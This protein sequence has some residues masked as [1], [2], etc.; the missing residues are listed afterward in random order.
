MRYLSSVR[1]SRFSGRGSSRRTFIVNSGQALLIGAGL[2]AGLGRARMVGAASQVTIGVASVPCQAPTYAA[3]AQGYFEDEGLQ[4]TAVVSAEVGEI[5]PALT[6]HKIDAGLSTVW[7]VVPPRLPT[8][9]ALGDVVITAPLQRGCL[10]LSVPPSSPVESLADLSGL[11]VAGSKFLYG[12]A[13]FEAGL[14]PNIDITWSAAPLAAD[15]LATLQAGE[16]AAVQSPDGQGALLEVAGVAR[17]I[18]MNNMSPSEVNYCCA[19][20]MNASSIQSDRP[21]AAAITRALMRGSAWAEAN[22]TE[23]AELMRSSMTLPAQRE[24][25][26]DDMEA[27][28][29]MQAFVPMADAARPI[30]ISEF[31]DYMAY[32]LPVSP[33]MDTATL[34]D[35]IFVPL[36]DELSG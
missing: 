23:T 10:A 16:F 4:P 30:L 24:I 28:L 25:A 2:A 34:I 11:K 29:A 35:R 3:L 6:S 5:L 13:I 21:R 12:A 31:D 1:T 9:I 8:A 17:M 26:R 14:D 32:G 36:T 18:G 22:R 15:V 27:A 33:P 19:C 7:A 20:L